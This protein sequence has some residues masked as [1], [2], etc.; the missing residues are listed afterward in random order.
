MKIRKLK[1][2]SVSALVLIILNKEC[3]DILRRMAEV[4]LRTRMQ[5]LGLAYDDLLHGEEK[6]INERGLDVKN[7]LMNPDVDMQQLMETYFMYR[8]NTSYDENGLLFSEKHLCNEANFGQ[9][10][11][12]RIC[13][14]EIDNLSDRIRTEEASQKGLL[15]IYLELLE[16]M[17]RVIKEERIEEIGDGISYLL[18]YNDATGQLDENGNWIHQYYTN[19]PDDKLYKMLCSKLGFLRLMIMEKLDDTWFESDLISD[20]YALRFVKRDERKLAKQKRQ[21]FEQVASGYQVDYNTP[22]MQKGLARI[23]KM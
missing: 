2:L 4:E 13:S 10:F 19:M 16:S 15:A 11:F 9:P 22:N 8:Y 17:Q 12:S 14:I 3:S 21:L 18:E 1:N 6:I 7:Y 20:L 23:R 5:G